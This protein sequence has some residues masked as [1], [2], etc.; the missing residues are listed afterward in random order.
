MGTTDTP[1]LDT[2]MDIT[3][4]SIE[5]NSVSPRDFM[6]A[7]L[8]ALIAVDAPPA[9]YLA[10]APAL[11]QAGL[12]EQDIEGIMIAVAPVVGTPR[13]TS[14]AGQILRALGMAIAVGDTG[15]QADK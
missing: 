6:L 12:T 3:T 1:V 5:H 4:A 13:V 15:E 9:S 7:R 2:I 14:A 8:A 10:N 11:A